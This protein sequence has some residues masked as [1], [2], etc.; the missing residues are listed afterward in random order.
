GGIV[1]AA[2]N[3]ETLRIINDKIAL[4]EM[5]KHYLCITLGR[6]TPPEGKI[7][8]FL[9]KDEAKKQVSV[10]HKP[11]P[12][13]KSAVTLYKTLQTKGELS[14]VEVQ[15]LTGRTHQIRA[16]FADAGHPLL[17][18]GKYGNG[19]KN[20]RYGET[21]QALYSYKLTFAFTTDAGMLNYLK[22]KTFTVE[23]VPFRDKYFP[24]K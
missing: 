18:D 3:A 7:E 23:T 10:Y 6:M 2:K 22:G 4:H 15:L 14:L 13:G 24:G 9:L 20:R 5:E 17:G 11:I 16:S 19:D 12:G 8:C 21:R 1:I